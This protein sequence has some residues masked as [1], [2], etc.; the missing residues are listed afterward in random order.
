MSLTQ[1]VGP[2]YNPPI[3][4]TCHV[5]VWFWAA[6]EAQGRG[7]VG[8]KTT[9]ERLKA[10]C[11]I[12]VGPQVAMLA[13]PRIGDRN[14]TWSSTLPTVGT[15]MVWTSGATHSAVALSNKIAGYN[16]GQQF[17]IIDHRYTLCTVNQLL[18]EHKKVHFVREEV[19]VTAAQHFGL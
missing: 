16:Q 14:Y 17:G 10:I 2:I 5:A 11:S 6:L 18:E 19:V 8:H 12:P 15:V 3:P 13:L 1:H 9:I 4:L 7:L